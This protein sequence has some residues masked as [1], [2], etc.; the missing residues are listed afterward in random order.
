MAAS[1]SSAADIQGKGNDLEKKRR[2]PRR[3][4]AVIGGGIEQARFG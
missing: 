4:V 2:E 3:P 1:A